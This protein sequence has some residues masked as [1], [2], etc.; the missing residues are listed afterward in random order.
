MSGGAVSRAAEVVARRIKAI[1]GHLL[2]VDADMVAFADG[3]ILAGNA[4]VSYADVGCAWYIRPDQLPESVDTG[5]LETTEGYKPLVDSGLYSY[6]THAARVA[7][8]PETGIVE[9]LDYV[10]VEDCGKMINPM[11]VEGQT[12]GGAAQ[13]IGTALFEESPYDDKRPATRFDA[14][15][16]HS[17]GTD[18]TAEVQDRASR[19]SFAVF[20]AWNQGVGEGGAIA[21]PAA[22]TNAINDALAQLDAVIRTIPASPERIRHA[23][24]RA[25][26]KRAGEP[27]KAAE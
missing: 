12:Y 21:P 14:A 25:D 11:I 6:A 24:R 27:A 7:V 17:A 8:D 18:R 4:S 1:A 3:R 20:G 22:I 23:I 26:R 10:V 5:G 9:I 2:Q 19:V 13:G 16:L 15:R